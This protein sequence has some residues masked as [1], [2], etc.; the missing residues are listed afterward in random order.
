MPHRCQCQLKLKGTVASLST[1]YP[2]PLLPSREKGGKTGQSGRLKPSPCMG[3]G[4]G[5]GG[6]LRGLA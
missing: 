4:L 3:E 6:K 2:Q 5:E 1:L